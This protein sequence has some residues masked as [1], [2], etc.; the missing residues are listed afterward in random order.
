MHVNNWLM[1]SHES[2]EKMQHRKGGG[3]GEKIKWKLSE[4]DTRAV[5]RGQNELIAIS[6]WWLVM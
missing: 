3:N 2:F 5:S 6:R 4:V 1:A